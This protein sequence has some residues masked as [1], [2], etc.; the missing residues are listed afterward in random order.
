MGL[1][2]YFIKLGSIYIEMVKSVKNSKSIM[3]LM[4]DR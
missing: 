2:F 1:D 4:L 3:L